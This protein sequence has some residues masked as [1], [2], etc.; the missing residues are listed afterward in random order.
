MTETMSDLIHKHV[1]LGKL[2]STGFYALRCPI[3][4]DYTER[5]GWKIEHGKVG[6][7][8]FNCSFGTVYKDSDGILTNKFKTLLDAL[9]VPYDAIE[10][11]NAKRFFRKEPEVITLESLTKKPNLFTREVELPSDSERITEDSFHLYNAYLKSRNLDC[12][13]HPFYVSHDK[14][15]KNRLI[16]PFY[17]YGKLIYWQGRT[18]V[19]DRLRYLNCDT[20]KEAVI[21]NIDKLYT[22]VDRPLFVTEGVFDAIHVNGV[23]LIGSKLNEAKIELLKQSQRELIFVVDYDK[24]GC[25]LAESV[26]KYNLGRLAFPPKRFDIDSSIKKYGKLWTYFQLVNS[27][28]KSEMEQRIALNLFKIGT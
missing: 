12:N 3:C 18:I 14:K 1:R 25:T 22:L 26:I 7:N 6:Y 20:P 16:I 8:C 5:A 17:R 21:F 13:S 19:N 9:H 10:E 23:A 28:P 11:V 4:H 27:I 24:N 15:F 2:S